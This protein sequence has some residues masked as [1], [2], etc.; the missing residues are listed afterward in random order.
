MASNGLKSIAYIENLSLEDSELTELCEQAMDWSHTHGFVLRPDEYKDRSDY[1]QFCPMTLFPSPFPRQLFEE[2]TNVQKLSSELYFKVAY[3]FEFLLES[4]APV[5]ETDEFTR[6]MV[7]IYKT[8]HKEGIR[9][10]FSLL[11]QGQIICRE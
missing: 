7:D 1:A 3:D 4:L 2:A 11:L 9:Q 5:I 10:K 8:V 6:K